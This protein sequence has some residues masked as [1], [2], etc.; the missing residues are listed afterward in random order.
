MRIWGSTRRSFSGT[1]SKLKLKSS[2]F[3]GSDMEKFALIKSA[4]LLAT[5][6][7]KESLLKEFFHIL[8]SASGAT[9]VVLALCDRDDRDGAIQVVGSRTP[10]GDL[11]LNKYP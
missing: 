1:V 7:T 4:Q 11:D 6:E 5:K 10:F 8:L 2:K 9:R 3:E